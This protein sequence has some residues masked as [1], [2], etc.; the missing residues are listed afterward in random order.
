MADEPAEYLLT[1]ATTM[2]IGLISDSHIPSMGRELPPQ[3]AR[4]FAGV[5]HIFHA[6]DIFMPEC[7]DELERI[8]PVTAVE[9]PPSSI[10]DDS[11]VTALQRVIELEGYAIGLVHVLTIPATGWEVMPGAIAKRI[12]LEQPLPA[13]IAQV[14][15][16]PVDIVVFGD[17]HYPLVEEHQGILFVNAGSPTLP[18]QLVKLG[19]V[20][21]LELTATGRQATIV[22]LAAYA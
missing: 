16:R 2:K 19:T 21:I 6:G 10:L 4:A 1:Y 8:A 17:T 13:L 18:R 7:L 15:G 11:R 20:G 14:F 3:V 12:G 5:D 22:D 9:Y